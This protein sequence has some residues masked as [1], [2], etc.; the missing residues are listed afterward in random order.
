MACLS[1]KAGQQLFPIL[2]HPN[3]LLHL[4]SRS[5]PQSTLQF[6]SLSQNEALHPLHPHPGHRRHGQRPPQARN[7][8]GRM[9]QALPLLRLLE[10]SPRQHRGPHPQRT[11]YRRGQSGWL[12][13]TRLYVFFCHCYCRRTCHIPWMLTLCSAHR[14]G[15]GQVL[16]ERSQVLYRGEPLGMLICLLA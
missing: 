8:Q 7:H 14:Q 4:Q 6:H 9:R 10:H 1:Y 13:W 12:D 11:G 15:V 5:S 16:P 3:Q 2:N